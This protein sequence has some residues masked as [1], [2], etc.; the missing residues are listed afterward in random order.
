MPF[1]V[2]DY[3]FK[4]LASDRPDQP[5]G[6]SILPRRSGAIGLSRIPIARNRRATRE[7]QT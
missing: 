2:Y 1:A 6:I 7:P 5:F 3:L 4:A